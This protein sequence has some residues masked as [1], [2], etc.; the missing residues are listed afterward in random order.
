MRKIA[1]LI[2]LGLL[3][4]IASTAALGILDADLSELAESPATVAQED[5]IDAGLR[6][7]GW[8]NGLLAL[9]AKERRVGHPNGLVRI[10]QTDATP[11]LKGMRLWVR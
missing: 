2:A 4:G 11:S 7:H 5:R 6:H 1:L 9:T 10:C 3:F 8:P